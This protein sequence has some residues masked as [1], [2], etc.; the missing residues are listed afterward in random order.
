[1]V[2]GNTRWTEDHVERLV[3][4]ML[5]AGV[6]LSGMVVLLGGAIYLARHGDQVP[7][8]RTF[9]GEPEELRTLSGI[10]QTT[11]ELRGRGMIQFG[12]LLL[13]ATP[14]IRV[15]V[16]GYAFF[17]QADYLYVGVSVVVLGILL[18]SLFGS[19]E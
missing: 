5:R 1:M 16:L 15:I 8:H 7:D 2:A 6:L 9:H 4:N 13:I 12:I 3:G 11:A 10:L 19:S 18:A 17:R 14:V